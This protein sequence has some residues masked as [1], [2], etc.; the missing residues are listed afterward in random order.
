MGWA[1]Q[2]HSKRCPKSS[3]A[4]AHTAA[5]FPGQ[6]TPTRPPSKG[7][8]HL[9]PTPGPQEGPVQ[10]PLTAL[11]PPHALPPLRATEACLPTLGPMWTGWSCSL[12]WPAGGPGLSRS[13]EALASRPT[14]PSTA[15]T[16]RPPTQ[17][18]SLTIYP[19]GTRACAPPHSPRMFPQC[20]KSR[21]PL[22]GSILQASGAQCSGY[23]KTAT[24]CQ[25]HQYQSR[26]QCSPPQ[27]QPRF[28]KYTVK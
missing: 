13:P 18:P 27:K 10:T 17:P 2:T 26:A 28:R 1:A 25:Q 15:T 23:E 8:H 16:R 7:T 20:G 22:F 21:I 6:P 19:T 4:R 14:P 9:L 3:L 11:H 5:L 24:A 12:A